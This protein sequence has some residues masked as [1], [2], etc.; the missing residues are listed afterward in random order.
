MAPNRAGHPLSAEYLGLAEWPTA[1]GQGSLAVE[2]RAD[3]A[4]EILA[5]L[6]ALDDT[7]TRVEITAERT[8]LSVLDAGCHAPVAT[9]ASLTDGDL[10][11]RAIVYALDGSHRIG[12]DRTVRLEP[13]YGGTRR[14]K[15]VFPSFPGNAS[16]PPG[17]ATIPPC[18]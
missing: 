14:V 13:G 16:T 9:H 15:T 17:R 12:I 6:A 5:A 4:P 10:R 18:P 8:I 7:A 2:T 1:P 11:L 3:I